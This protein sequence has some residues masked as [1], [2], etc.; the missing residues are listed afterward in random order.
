MADEVRIVDIDEFDV[1][2]HAAMQ[3]RVFGH[4]LEENGIPLERM[5]ADVFA[6]KLSPPQGPGRAAIVERGGRMVASCSA[7]P[8]RLAAGETR[9]L[10]W[11]LTDAATFKEARGG[12]LFGRIMIALRE[13]MPNDA[14][15]FAFPNDKSL[16]AFTRTDYHP[17]VEIPLWFRPTIGKGR[18]AE[19]LHSLSA[20]GPEHDEF[21]DRWAALHQLGPLRHAA[22]LNW[23]YLKHPY[24]DYQCFEL[25]RDGNVLGILVLNR[26][27]ARDRV[28]LWVM[29]LLALDTKTERE[30]A[31]SARYLAK[32]Q[33]C[34]VV[35]SMASRKLPGSFRLPACFIPKKHVLMVRSGGTSE[36][37]P[38]A[39][40]T[41]Q[42]GDWDTF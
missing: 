11:H 24:F 31:L 27:K 32:E 39:Q 9:P 25:R 22:Y 21:A 12:G 37:A 6:W 15:T 17:A 35:L 36:P 7:Y 10:G 20:F 33:E 38:A 4:V 40:W 34:D 23:R 26:M 13:S 8:L 5:S 42:T 16:G 30:L 19:G 3:Q 28:S 18:L 29:E 1:E 14:W 41:V 2:Q